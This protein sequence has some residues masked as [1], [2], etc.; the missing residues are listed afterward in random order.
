MADKFVMAHAGARKAEPEPRVNDIFAIMQSLGEGLR[1]FLAQFNRV[2]MTL[3]NVSKGMAVAAFQNGLIRDGSIATR[4]LLSRLMKYP[5][6]TWEKIHNAY[7]DVVRV[8]ED[9]LNG[10]TH[11][12]VSVQ[13]E[14][15]KERRDTVGEITRFCDPTRNHTS[16]TSGPPPHLLSAIKKAHQ[17]R[18][19]ELTGMK[20][21][22]SCKQLQ[23][24]HLKELLSDK[25]RNNFARGREHQGPAKPPSPA[26]TINMIIDG[27]NGASINNVKFTTTQKLKRSITHERYDRLEENIVF[28]ESDADGLTFPHNDALVITLRI[29]DTNVKRIMVDD[30]SGVCIIHPRVLAWMRLE[31]KVVPHFI[32]LT[33]FNNA[34]EWTSGEIKLPVLAGGITLETIPHHGSGHRE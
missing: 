27:G 18:E 14:S 6:T 1:D 4:K 8:D 16:H 26:C 22:R 17:G 13:A 33:D 32:T 30:G 24:G 9:D 3:P 21:A 25:G 19:W 28:N 34:V 10:P 5:P 20:E 29:L 31:D 23:Q 2:R 12:L 7:C 15:R 11:R